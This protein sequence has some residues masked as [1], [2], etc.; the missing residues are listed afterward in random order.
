MKKK[1]KKK[2][3][4][5]ISQHE[6][7]ALKVTAQFF[8]DEIMPALNIEGTVVSILPT[9]EV[10]LE[11]RKGFEDFNYLMSDNSI[12]HFEF[13]STNEG[14][15]G[16]KRFRIYESQMSYKYKKAVTTYVLFSG[17]IQNPMTEF[18]EGM[19]TYRV[20]PIIM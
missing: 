17:N 16:L 6:D 5:K 3:P 14:I 8:R 7:A 11:L 12:K 9:E 18:T 20:V 2:Q 19:N 4:A 15:C 13:Q 10:H 1:R